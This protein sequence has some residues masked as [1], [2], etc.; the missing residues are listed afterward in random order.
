MFTMLQA[1]LRCKVPT[2]IGIRTLLYIAHVLDK[3]SMSLLVLLSA[4]SSGSEPNPPK[5][6]PA[7]VHVF[8]P[9]DD[10]EC[11]TVAASIFKTNGGTDPV[12]N[13]GQF[14]SSR[15]ALLFKPGSYSCA[16]PVGFYTQVRGFR[17]T[18]RPT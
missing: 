8:S 6:P 12:S 14:V 9:G 13:N 7:S 10:G 5:W 4:A 3:A 2:R 18:M 1:L 11:A 17:T 16:V 15:H